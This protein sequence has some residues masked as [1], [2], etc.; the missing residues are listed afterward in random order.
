MATDRVLRGQLKEFLDF[1]SAH[2]GFDAAV[3]GFPPRLRGAV[4][5]GFEHSVWQLLEHIRIAQAD[6]LDFCVNPKYRHDMKWPDDYWPGKPAPPSGVAWS[7]SVAA[8]LRD[9]RKM[10]LLAVNPRINLTARIPHGSGQTYLREI[11]LVQ[12]HAAYH[13]AQIVD[14]R[15]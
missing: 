12:D 9:R 5:K 3:K 2:V 15:R 10:Q 14:V 4:P 11:L 7:K 6:I 13:L 1:R 8:I